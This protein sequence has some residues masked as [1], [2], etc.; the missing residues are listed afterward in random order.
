LLGLLGY[1]AQFWR[2]GSLPFVPDDAYAALGSRG[3]LV[4]IVP[5]REL[6]VVRTGLDPEVGPVIWRQDRFLS[7]LIEVLP[8]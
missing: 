8:E 4:A 1:G 2:I 3:Q 5:S 6:V 7:D